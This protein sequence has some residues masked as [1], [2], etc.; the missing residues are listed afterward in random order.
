MKTEELESYMLQD[1]YIQKYYGGVVP[2]DQIP[3]HVQKPSVYI[4][5]SDPAGL[6]GKHW[7]TVFFNSINE[8]FDSAG[9]YP[10]SILEAELI[11][12]GPRFQYNDNRVQAYRS[13]TCG[14]FCLF[15]CYFRCRG[16]LFKD[17]MNMFSN[18]L[19]VNEYVVEY[20]YELTK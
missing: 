20:F 2:L 6:P 10:N 11:S 15:Y 1:P 3:I 5:N 19:Q 18:N 4:V 17:I 7:Y 13:D 9:F 8:H 16:Y 12:H 14:L